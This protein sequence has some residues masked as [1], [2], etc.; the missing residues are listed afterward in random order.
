[1]RSVPV[2]V[3][4]L[5]VYGLGCARTLQG[6]DASEFMTLAAV[7]GVAHPPGYPL[8]TYWVQAVV[9]VLPG[10]QIPWQASFASALCGAAAVS[11]LHAALR[12]LTRHEGVALV[13][14]GVLAVHPVFWRYATV[15]EVFTMAA[16]TAAG[17]VYVAARVNAGWRGWRPQLALGLVVASGIANHHTVVLLAPL[18]V[19]T[20]WTALERPARDVAVCAAAQLVGFLFYVPLMFV[21]SGLRWGDTSTFEGLVHH[22]LRRDYGTF[23]LAVAEHEVGIWEHPVAFL[24]ELGPSFGWVFAGLAIY[25]MVR[26]VKDRG[27][28]LA[29]SASWLLAGP[30]FLA[31][32]NLPA[33]YGNMVV[34]RRFTIVPAVL[35]AGL[36]ALAL[37]RDRKAWWLA[38][39]VVLMGA[40][41]ASDAS[42]AKWTVLEDY[43][44]NSLQVAEPN[45][46]LV[47][48]SDNTLFG[49]AYLQRVEGLRP[50]VTVLSPTMLSYDWY[51]AGLTE[52][53]DTVRSVDE[54]LVATRRPTYVAY[55]YYEGSNATGRPLALPEPVTMLR[56]WPDDRPLPHPAQLEQAM[57]ANMAG[58]TFRSGIETPHQWYDT[59]ESWAVRQYIRGFDTLAQGYERVGD[60]ESA[61]RVR[62]EAQALSPYSE[63][64]KPR[65][66]PSP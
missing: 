27:L 4:L 55:V 57:D 23:D 59:W 7:G 64:L 41:N 19:W 34:A 33:D 32:F 58:F 12:T 56:V 3:T 13:G 66:S 45:A 62:S 20:F 40:L 9:S 15:A 29:L 63:M 61:D 65:S 8:F 10:D 48:A 38:P 35:F 43:L 49:S 26:S 6:G 2:F 39:V 31:K 16:L 22:L 24:M 17:M 36:A 25:A 42:H 14:A 5:V 52:P 21:E 50:D 51:R 37:P 18:A 30:L 60:P 11:V 28:A 44:R 54:A 53:Y 47:V 1:M 46:V